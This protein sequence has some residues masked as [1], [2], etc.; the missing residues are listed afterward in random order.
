MTT[1][2]GQMAEVFRKRELSITKNLLVVFCLFVVCFLPT[3]VAL[4]I[5]GG[6][7]YHVY[8]MV[9]LYVSAC[10]NPFV[11]G[12]KHAQF[13][14]VL[15]PLVCCRCAEIPEP[16]RLLRKNRRVAVEHVTVAMSPD[17]ECFS[18]YLL[19][20]HQPGQAYTL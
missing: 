5:P 10:I 20:H 13:K 1:G 8:A 2:E 19:R 6:H 9:L 3:A 4:I 11:Y 14:E 16:T 18:K 17:I 15:R 7:L 12:L